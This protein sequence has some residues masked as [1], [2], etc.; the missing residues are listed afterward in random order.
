MGANLIMDAKSEALAAQTDSP[1]AVGSAREAALLLLARET[2]DSFLDDRIAARDRFA[3]A[4]EAANAVQDIQRLHLEFVAAA[5]RTYASQALT[6]H[7]LL[8]ELE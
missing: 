5:A 3:R 1:A 4:I 7:S 2:F 8:S 6:F